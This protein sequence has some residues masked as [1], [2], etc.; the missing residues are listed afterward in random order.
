LQQG[1][2][3]SASDIGRESGEQ[4]GEPT[5]RGTEVGPRKD[6]AGADNTDADL[7]RAR[8]REHERIAVHSPRS[9]ELIAGNNRRRVAGQRRRIGSK[10]ANERADESASG[11]P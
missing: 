4:L 10:V 6:Q 3:E 5:R 1:A 9:A 7:A 11:A 8:D 2:R